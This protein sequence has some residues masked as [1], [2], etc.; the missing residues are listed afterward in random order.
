MVADCK[1]LNNKVALLLYSEQEEQKPR[2][3]KVSKVPLMASTCTHS[4]VPLQ[5]VD[6]R[7]LLIE[8]VYLDLQLKTSR[9]LYSKGLRG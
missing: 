2:W 1:P 9:C 7:L 6:V 4:I 8:L 5:P 3:E